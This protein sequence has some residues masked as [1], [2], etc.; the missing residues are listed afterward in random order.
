MHSFVSQDFVNELHSDK[1]VCTGSNNLSTSLGLI[2]ESNDRLC[3]NYEESKNSVCSEFSVSL[4]F[5]FNTCSQK[6]VSLS[7]SDNLVD[8]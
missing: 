5:M 7:L 8:L 6:L 2:L 3:V 1:L 4:S